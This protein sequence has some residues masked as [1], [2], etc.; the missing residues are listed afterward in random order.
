MKY[1]GDKIFT[2]HLFEY[3]LYTGSLLL[4]DKEIV[5]RIDRI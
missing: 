4:L 5:I 2:K 3:F 1:R